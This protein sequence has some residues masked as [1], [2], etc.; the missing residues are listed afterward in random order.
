MLLWYRSG[1]DP[2]TGH[3][4]ASAFRQILVEKFS[5]PARKIGR[6]HA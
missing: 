4:L 1:F 6:K 5:V 3:M 2:E